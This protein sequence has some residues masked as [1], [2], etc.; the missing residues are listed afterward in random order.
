MYSV[1]ENAREDDIKCKVSHVKG[2]RDERVTD[3][4]LIIAQV[5][6]FPYHSGIHAVIKHGGL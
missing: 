2:I 1:L 5:Q 3:K 4:I 6:S